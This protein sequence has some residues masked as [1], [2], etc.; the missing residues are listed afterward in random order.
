M[1]HFPSIRNILLL[2]D[3]TV[4]ERHFCL[5]EFYF[6]LLVYQII[7]IFY[8]VITFVHIFTWIFL[9]VNAVL[10]VIKLFSFIHVHYCFSLTH[11]Q[12][13]LLVHDMLIK[14]YLSVFKLQVFFAEFLGFFLKMF[15]IVVV[16]VNFETL[17]DVIL[18]QL[19]FVRVVAHQS[20]H[21]IEGF[22]LVC[23]HFIRKLSDGE[24]LLVVADRFPSPDPIIP[25]FE[26]S[27]MLALLVLADAT[28]VGLE[29]RASLLVAREWKWSDRGVFAEGF[30][31]IHAADVCRA[32][33]RHLG[34]QLAFALGLLA[35]VVVSLVQMG[36]VFAEA[37]SAE[38][39]CGGAY[40]FA[41][42]GL[43]V[44]PVDL[45]SFGLAEA[46]LQNLLGL[47]GEDESLF[48]GF[49]YDVVV[50]LVVI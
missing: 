17:F 37:V 48:H 30:F 43:G 44:D 49:P 10:A 6:I 24:A 12:R 32:L 5:R 21:G 41:I 13:V 38:T 50:C 18:L 8:K 26:N 47:G 29:L 25:G 36:H 4:I 40:H 14:I 27:L 22:T 19:S 34:L 9:V 31:A 7:L 3:L 2:P 46:V 28:H 11:S 15:D 1:V 33:D 16:F 20:A 23:L 39:E 35:A 45:E 42:S